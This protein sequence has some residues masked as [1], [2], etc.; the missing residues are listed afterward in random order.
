MVKEDRAS[1]KR[2]HTFGTEVCSSNIFGDAIKPARFDAFKTAIALDK[3]F[4]AEVNRTIVV[5]KDDT[6]AT[7]DDKGTN[8]KRKEK[9]EKGRKDY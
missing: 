9:E 2:I 8:K 1:E 6:S 3:I 5:S 7:T 4:S